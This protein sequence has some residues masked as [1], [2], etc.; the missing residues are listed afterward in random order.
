MKRIF[1]F[2]A[3]FLSLTVQT[4]WMQECLSIAPSQINLGTGSPGTPFT[5]TI[6]ITNSS[7][8]GVASGTLSEKADWITQIKPSVFK[9]PKKAKALAT[10]SGYFPSQKGSFATDVEI[11]WIPGGKT[12]RLFCKSSG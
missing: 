7:C 2:V 11:K 6:T 12:K 3:L 9:L 10:V 1:F 5:R 4:G 8:K